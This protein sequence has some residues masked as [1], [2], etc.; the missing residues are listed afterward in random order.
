MPK[1]KKKIPESSFKSLFNLTDEQFYY[2]KLCAETKDK[3]IIK[4]PLMKITEEEAETE[5]KKTT[6][7][8]KKLKKE[9]KSQNM[10]DNFKK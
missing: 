10:A 1:K 7:R 5:D 2:D 4:H 3:L 6:E 8:Y 9:I